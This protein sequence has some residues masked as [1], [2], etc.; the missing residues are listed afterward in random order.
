MWWGDYLQKAQVEEIVCVYFMFSFGLFML[1]CVPPGTTQYIFHMPL[2]RYSLFV[3]KV[4]LNINNLIRCRLEVTSVM[5]GGDR[6]EPLWERVG[7]RTN[8]PWCSCVRWSSISCV[9]DAADETHRF[10]VDDIRKGENNYTSVWMRMESFVFPETAGSAYRV[11][12]CM[13]SHCG[14]PCELLY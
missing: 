11:V 12:H 13:V 7:L 8:V 5:M 1:A 6:D 14:A 3:L 2:A 9:A 4:P 10:T